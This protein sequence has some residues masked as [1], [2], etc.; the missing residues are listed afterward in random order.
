MSIRETILY[1]SRFFAILCRLRKLQADM[2]VAMAGKAAKVV[3]TERQQAV[4]RQLSRATTVVFRLRQRARIILLAFEG[5]RNEEI[6]TLVSLGRD[7]VGVWRRRWQAA[8]EQLTIIEGMEGLPPLRKAI[9]N[10]LHDEQ[11]AGAPP[12]F[13][14][15][16]L[17]MI[18]A[19]ACEAVEE[20]GRPVARWTQKEIIAEAVSR[21]ILPSMST[22]QLSVLLAEAQLQPHK[23]RYWLN[24]RE[25]DLTVFEQQATEVCQA[26]LE[27]DAMAKNHNTRTICIDEMTSIQAIERKAPKKRC[28]PD[29]KNASSLNIP[30][31]EPS[32]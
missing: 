11:R 10:V 7:Q 26:Y 17:T 25:T 8:F 12:T 22:S 4:L 15:E 6:E 21:G 5:K 1:E 27:A 23:S 28:D 2:E 19:I 16:Q 20:S 9:E 30:A 31:T 14:P 18:F 32:V 29:K 24:T 13:T 3:I